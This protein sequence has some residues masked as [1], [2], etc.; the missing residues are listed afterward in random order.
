M[1]ARSDGNAI[2][3]AVD[4][5]GT[6]IATDLLWEGLFILIKKN[7]LYIFLVP[8]WAAAGPARL[9]QAIAQRVD[10]DPASLP[11][12]APL[13]DR[14][15]AEHA[16]GRKIVLATGTP[17]KFA[18]AIARHLGVFDRVLA[19]DGVD[20]LTSG[21]KRA[22][23]VAAYGDGGF[24]YAGN[25]RHDLKVFDAARSAIVV[26]PDRHAARWQAAHG[27]E[28]MSAPKPTLRTI[29]KMLRVHQWLKNSLIA[30]PMVLSHEYFNAGMI[31]ECV[32]AFISFSAVASAIYILNDF[33]DLALDRKHATKRHR[34]FAS[35]ALSIPFGI[36][37]IAVLLAIGIG[38]GLFLAP[39]FL[40]V[41][42]GY[43]AVTTAYSLS[44]KRMLLVDVLTLAGLYTI[45]VLA[46]AAATGVEV[47]FW[48]LAFSIFFFLSLALVKRFVELRTTAILPGERI[49]GRGYRTED[50]EIVAQAGMA[51]AFS[52]ALVLALY[53]DSVAV[54]ELYPHPWLIWPL[55]PIVLYLTMRV[56]ILAR[57][58]EMHDDPV[59]FIIRDWRSQIVVLIGAV[60]L[61]IGGW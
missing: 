2:P 13:L 15:R 1:D 6:L 3:L 46:G 53:M 48:L 25:S 56:W 14:I 27:A 8:F 20:N 41:L 26:A 29:V 34:P 44:F 23:L 40:A 33:F 54:R 58:D 17:R 10:I 42:G 57:R 59:V 37:A 50:Q 60:L 49:A 28:T 7:P 32:L 16:E 18:D 52:S 4:L 12:R 39:E 36:G 30:V 47:S 5:D 43:M 61:V 45:R 21:K 11:Y 35:G 31:W 24:D 22:S 38:T 19:S 51:S 9:K 55:P